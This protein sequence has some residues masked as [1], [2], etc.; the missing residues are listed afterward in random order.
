MTRRNVASILQL[1]GVAVLVVWAAETLPSYV[2]LAVGLILL[3]IVL[4]QGL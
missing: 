3:G 4:E 1:A 2:V